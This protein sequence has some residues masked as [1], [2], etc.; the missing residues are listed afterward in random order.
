VKTLPKRI[1]VGVAA[2]IA[3]SALVLAPLAA[4][5]G[6]QP[7]RICL[8]NA[9]ASQCVSV[10]LP[11]AESGGSSGDQAAFKPPQRGR[12]DAK[13]HPNYGQVTPEYPG[14]GDAKDHPNYGQ[15]TPEY[16][17]RGDAKDHPNY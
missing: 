3:G 15:V 1:G 7:T 11:Q 16:P 6:A 14:R 9:S 17:G 2:T 12:G 8:D 10:V 13:D 5:A 4:A